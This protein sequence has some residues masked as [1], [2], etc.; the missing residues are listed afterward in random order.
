MQGPQ[1]LAG[2]WGSAPNP[3]AAAQNASVASVRRTQETR[4]SAPPTVP[5]TTSRHPYTLGYI[6]S[7]TKRRGLS[8]PPFVSLAT[9]RVSCSLTVARNAHALCCGTGSWGAAPNP[10]KARREACALW[11]EGK[12]VPGGHLREAQSDP[13][14]GSETMSATVREARMIEQPGHLGRRPKATRS[15]PKG[16]VSPVGCCRQRRQSDPQV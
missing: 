2:V 15:A 7:H 3:C 13:K 11:R 4:L 5:R 8:A 10:G 6:S 12:R 14:R 1:A 9:S 16:S